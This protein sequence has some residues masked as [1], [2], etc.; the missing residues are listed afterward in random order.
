MVPTK[1]PLTLIPVKV[2][3]YHDEAEDPH[4]M[5][6]GIWTL[7]QFSRRHMHYVDPDD[8]GIER[9]PDN[10]ITSTD[11]DLAEKLRNGLAFV[12]SYYEHGRCAWSIY[13]TGPQCRWDNVG[14]AGILVW[15]NDPSDMGAETIEERQ[16]DAAAFLDTYTA[17]CN[18]D[19]YGYSI[20][21]TEGDIDDA[22]GGYYG[23]DTEYMLSEIQRAVGGRPVIFTGEAKYLGDDY[24]GV[25]FDRKIHELPADDD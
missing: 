15:E 1:D 11:P 20:T 22:C 10:A 13:G 18:G 24:K 2:E 12:V 21:D 25:K 5:G 7:K 17:W 9:G 19:V 8:L 16:K 6:D 3:L 23:P 4:D 14:I